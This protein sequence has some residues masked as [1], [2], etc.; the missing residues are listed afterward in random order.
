MSC[1]LRHASFPT[2]IRQR[3]TRRRTHRTQSKSFLREPCPTERNSAVLDSQY[4]LSLSVH[5]TR[6]GLVGLLFMQRRQCVACVRVRVR[7]LERKR[8]GFLGSRPAAAVGTRP[9]RTHSDCDATEAANARLSETYHFV[10]VLKSSRRSTNRWARQCY[11]GRSQAGSRCGRWRFA[12]LSGSRGSLL[13]T[14]VP[15][16]TAGVLRRWGPGDPASS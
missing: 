7:A 5:H 3:Q 9:N 6:R 1:A 16:Q 14:G 15:A 4:P 2:S 13:R 12:F 11:T 10:Y 8:G